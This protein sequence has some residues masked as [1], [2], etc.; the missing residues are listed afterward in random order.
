MSMGHE[1]HIYHEIMSLVYDL[2]ERLKAET[3]SLNNGSRN[4][5]SDFWSSAFKEFYGLIL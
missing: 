1:R 2:D 3:V 4:L 5:Q